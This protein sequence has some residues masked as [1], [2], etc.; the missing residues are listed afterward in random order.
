MIFHQVY[1][2][3][4]QF[5]QKLLKFSLTSPISTYTLLDVDMTLAYLWM[6][7]DNETFKKSEKFR[8]F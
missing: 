2:H 3:N 6:M 4:I 8:R 5:R 7:F 1:F